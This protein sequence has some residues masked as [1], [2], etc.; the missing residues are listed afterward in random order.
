MSQEKP[1]AEGSRPRPEG[2]PKEARL[3]KRPAFTNVYRAGRKLQG[4]RFVVFAAPAATGGVRLGITTTKKV[5]D[6]VVRNHLRRQVRE[7]YRRWRAAKKVLHGGGLELVV[8]V[9]EQAPGASFATLRDELEPL[10]SRAAGA[11]P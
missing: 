10:L 6:A 7:I 9:T 4:R 11:R 2:L 3:R 1:L 5:G 8:N